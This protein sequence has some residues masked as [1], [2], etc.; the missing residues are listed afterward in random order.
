VCDITG[1]EKWQEVASCLGRSVIVEGE[2]HAGQQE[3]D[4][5]DPD[6]VRGCVFNRVGMDDDEMTS[7][8]KRRGVEKVGW[9]LLV[10]GL[11]GVV[12]VGS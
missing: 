2:A 1:F 7:M 12:L 4:G 9:L 5:V 10:F 6:S 3:G 11:F 8:A